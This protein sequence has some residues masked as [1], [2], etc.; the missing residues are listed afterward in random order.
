[1][2]RKLPRNLQE[3]L[4]EK[5]CDH[6]DQVNQELQELR[7]FHQRNSCHDCNEEFHTRDCDEHICC[8]LCKKS[9]CY[10]SEACY[11]DDGSVAVCERRVGER[12]L[13]EPQAVE[14]GMIVRDGAALGLAAEAVVEHGELRDDGRC[15]VEVGASAGAFRFFSFGH[16]R[17]SCVSK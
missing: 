13:V 16:D 2:T 14:L 9:Y 12:V 8:E 11:P 4:V 7:E 1:M 5:V 6:L 10:D 3:Y 17:A 15:A